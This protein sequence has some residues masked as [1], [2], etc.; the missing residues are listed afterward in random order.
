[1]K[2]HALI[3]ARFGSSRLPGKVFK[4]IGNFT[5][6]ELMLQRLKLS[7]NLDSIIVIAPDTE[8]PYF[9]EFNEAGVSLFF[10]SEENVLQRHYSAALAFSKADIFLKIPSDCIFIDP[11]LI[12]QGIDFYKAGGFDYVTNI[13]PPSWPDGNDFEIFSF[14]VLEWL[15]KSSHTS[16]ER[17]HTTMALW[18]KDH[19]FKM[20]NLQLG[21]D[22]ANSYRW[23]LD[24]SEDLSFFRAIAKMFPGSLIDFGWRDLVLFLEENPDIQSLNRR[25]I[26]YQWYKKEDYKLPEIPQVILRKER[27]FH[28]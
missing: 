27:V 3:Q 17:E 2:F 11:D 18:T 14:L 1:M 16:L 13:V 22:L 5:A 21:E 10:G 8:K 7:K 24:Y 12:D 25:H 28:E 9:S 23:V 6:L 20:V 15:E 4:Q 19:S 26:D